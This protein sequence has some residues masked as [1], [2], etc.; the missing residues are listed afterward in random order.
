MS[1]NPR[2]IN[3]H[4]TSY[5]PYPEPL[6]TPFQLILIFVIHLKGLLDDL[7]WFAHGIG[8][9]NSQEWLLCKSFSLYMERSKR[10][11][12]KQNTSHESSSK[13]SPNVELNF[14][15]PSFSALLQCTYLFRHS[16]SQHGC[17]TIPNIPSINQQTWAVL[18]KW[19]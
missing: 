3:L 4:I 13:L 8:T 2:V 16:I 19:A 17:F 12:S 1:P 10:A 15:K 9:T 5:L 14:W 18:S 7:W 11:S 6:S